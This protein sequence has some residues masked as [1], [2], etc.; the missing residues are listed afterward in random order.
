M[1]QSTPSAVL[2]PVAAPDPDIIIRYLL[3]EI[4]HLRSALKQLSEKPARRKAPKICVPGRLLFLPEGR[5]LDM[6]ISGSPAV[7][8]P[9]QP[10]ACT[11]LLLSAQ[12]GTPDAPTPEKPAGK[13]PSKPEKPRQLTLFDMDTI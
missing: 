11:P 5:D 4:H 10:D 7:K 12:V 2:E 13:N 8:S 3:A 6:Q 1:T 9:V